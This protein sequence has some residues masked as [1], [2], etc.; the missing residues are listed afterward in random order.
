MR[1]RPGGSLDENPTHH[2]AMPGSAKFNWVCAS[3]TD[4]PG[5]PEIRVSDSGVPT[6]RPGWCAARGPAVADR[7]TRR[8]VGAAKILRNSTLL[9]VFEQFPRHP[10]AAPL[11]FHLWMCACAIL[12]G[13]ATTFGRCL[14]VLPTDRPGSHPTDRPA[15]PRTAASGCADRPTGHE[16]SG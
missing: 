2:R 16:P 15:R 11:I 12:S 4:R 7:P 5:L 14:G 3:P 1:M 13:I 8:A 10:V 6:D 9:R